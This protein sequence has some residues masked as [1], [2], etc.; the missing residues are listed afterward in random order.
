MGC[1]LLSLR[2]GNATIIMCSILAV[3]LSLMLAGPLQMITYVEAG[4]DHGN[5]KVGSSNLDKLGS[6]IKGLELPP[7][8][9]FNGNVITCAAV[10]PCVGTNDDDIM[11]CGI[12][13]RA[14]AFD[15]DDLVYG[16]GLGDQVYGGKG[17]DL[18]IAG[19]G[20][21]L[22]D[23][24]PN[25][26]VLMGGLGNNLLAGGNGN[27]KLFNGAG[28]AVMYG[29]KG[30][31]HFDCSLSALGLARSVV[32]DYNPSNGDT[33]SGPC[34]IVNTIGNNGDSTITLPDTGETTSTEVIPGTQ[35][36]S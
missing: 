19:A 35:I 30:A 11:F 8:C 10:V 27:D 3:S 14:F 16:G 17:D 9:V 26:D 12:R 33:I 6:K 36:G 18:L 7:G 29:G 25:D 1:G 23:G 28:T 34:K 5:S 31:N 24:G 21:S 2:R 32:M 13:S 4:N 22:L 20:K 15:G